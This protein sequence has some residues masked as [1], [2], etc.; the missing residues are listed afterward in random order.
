MHPTHI[1]KQVSVESCTRLGQRRGYCRGKCFVHVVGYASVE[2]EWTPRELDCVQVEGNWYV[3]VPWIAL[4]QHPSCA[5]DIRFLARNAFHYF[6]GVICT[7]SINRTYWCN[8][9]QCIQNKWRRSWLVRRV[10]IITMTRWGFWGVASFLRRM[11]YQSQGQCNICKTT[12]C[13]CWIPPEIFPIVLNHKRID[14]DSGRRVFSPL[15]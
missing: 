2:R 12:A 7:A 3:N 1:L 6:L 10:E 14:Q 5:A 9:M 8:H 11:Q 15:F 4:V 13:K